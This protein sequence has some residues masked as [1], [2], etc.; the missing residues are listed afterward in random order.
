MLRGE[1]F[2]LAAPRAV[3]GHEQRGRRFGVVLQADELITLSTVLVAPSSR[4]A[5][6]RTF[7]PEIE[8]DGAQT[9]LLIEQTTAVAPERLGRSLGVLS[10]REQ[11]AVDRAVETVFG[12]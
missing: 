1:I 12:L 11:R 4:S 10:A 6:A 8:I 5:A 2:E 3:R 7:R 9:R